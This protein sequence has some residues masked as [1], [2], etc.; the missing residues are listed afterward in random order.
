MINRLLNSLRS[1]W[2]GVGPILAGT[3]FAAA[4]VK[5]VWPD[6][7]R[8]AQVYHDLVV[9]D[10][11]MVNA[12]KSIDYVAL[13]ILIGVSLLASLCICLIF[14]RLAGDNS[15]S[16]TGKA[17]SQ[18]LL[19]SLI[20]AAWRIGVACAIDSDTLP[21]F[22]LLALFPLA[23]V[24]FALAALRF[25]K[26]LSRDEIFTCGGAVLM[27]PVLATYSAFGIVVATC[28]LFPSMVPSMAVRTA[29][30]AN[31]GMVVGVALVF[32]VLLVAPTVE[33]ARRW[34][35]RS[36]L[37]SQVLTPL[38]FFTCIPPPIIDHQNRF[39][40]Q[41]LTALVVVL[42]VGAISGMVAILRRLRL[43]RST[44]GLS[45][46][47]APVSV[48][49]L[50]VFVFCPLIGLP[51]ANDD[52]FHWGEH[53][54]PWQQAFSFGKLPYVD[55]AP[56]HG[57]MDY[58]LGA[59]THWFFTGAAADYEAGTSLMIAL[60]AAVTA[61]TMSSAVGSVAALL[62]LLAP[63]PVYDRVYLLAPG[64][65]VLA[66]PWMLRRPVR[67]LVTWLCVGLI[68]TFYN[69]S[70]G[71]ALVM[72]TMPLAAYLGY[73]AFKTDRR[74][75]KTLLI[76]LLAIGIVA[77]L[78]SPVRHIGIG[79]AHFLLD[80]S[81]TN[82]TANGIAYSQ[83]DRARE[84]TTGFSSTQL[85]FELY[86]M[87]WILVAIA[88][89]V[90]FWRELI[91]QRRAQ[92]LVLSGCTALLLIFS[93]SFALNR[94][95]VGSFGR[96]GAASQEAIY[97][98]LPPLLVLATPVTRRAGT[99]L[100][101]SPLLGFL[102]IRPPTPLDIHALDARATAVRKV[103]ADVVVVDG[104]DYGMPHLGR[105]VK[106]N[107]DFLSE[108][109]NQRDFM[110]TL[111]HPGETYFDFSS[112]IG[113]FY[114]LNFP[115]PVAY[116]PYVAGN[117]RLQAVLLHQL[118]KHPV[119]VV[120]VARPSN[121]HPLRCYR[122]FRQL[123][124]NFVAVRH[125][126]FVFLVDP[127]RLPQEGPIGSEAQLQ[128]LDSVF[129]L[130]DLSMIAVSWG[131]S[132]PSLRDELD[133]VANVDATSC[134]ESHDVRLNSHGKFVAAG[135][136]PSLTYALPAEV[137]DGAASDYLHVALECVARKDV[138]AQMNICWQ[139]ADGQFTSPV[140]FNAASEANDLIIPLGASPRWILGKGLKSIRLGFVPGTVD[141]IKL[142]RLQF[143]RLKGE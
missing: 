11:T 135:P 81:W 39:G 124:L 141:A 53:V 79:F 9:G 87:G 133:V 21:P 40:N 47:L 65:L 46:I 70:L 139:Q 55:F 113:F 90:F 138:P 136:A 88:S 45:E 126:T 91:G 35:L 137:A 118:R 51:H 117:R 123:V 71:P 59:C 15:E 96:P 75:L 60:A 32:L 80:N 18:L 109:A 72:A 3:L 22:I 1:S 69:A 116:D 95:D 2:F 119:H 30:F 122:V 54:L 63:V 125:G 12:N 77:F 78:I 8:R 103:P 86:R 140:L 67:S 20:P 76:S 98:L 56:I 43:T 38:L 97:F 143:L 26:M 142:K 19:I 68:C 134:T 99:I 82:V 31:T 41:R 104:K 83:S 28:R 128:I 130:P 74:G 16:E 58:T 129:R 112:T 50:A 14:R 61:L 111:L 102:C 115:C 132:W 131:R 89:A 110:L 120:M 25:R 17:I 106:P 92:V 57:L 5:A 100:A 66:S 64:L 23:V 49:A 85:F 62:I 108:I 44:P 52:F 42:A 36:L 127:R 73:K 114:Y 37:A 107:P 27:T 93:A 48:A 33:A 10:I 105:V 4:L 101:I 24:G 94:L 34:L 6:L 13:A 29:K 84:W 7:L 121:L